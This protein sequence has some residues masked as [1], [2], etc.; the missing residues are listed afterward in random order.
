MSHFGMKEAVTNDTDDTY[1]IYQQPSTLEH[2]G[3]KDTNQPTKPPVTAHTQ[4]LQHGGKHTRPFGI[5]WLIAAAIVGA[6]LVGA[7][8]G[9]GL[10]AQYASCNNKLDSQANS[11]SA[12]AE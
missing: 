4:P 12:E 2:H 3:Y 6:V 8:V 1:K 11:V 10:G 5:G 7:A 9:G